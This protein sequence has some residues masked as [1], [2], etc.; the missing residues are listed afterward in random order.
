MNIVSWLYNKRI[1]ISN[2]GLIS[3]YHVVDTYSHEWNALTGHEKLAEFYTNTPHKISKK[4]LKELGV[5]R[6]VNCSGVYWLIRFN[7]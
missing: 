6:V 7:S 2:K 3:R 4:A 5:S 1:D